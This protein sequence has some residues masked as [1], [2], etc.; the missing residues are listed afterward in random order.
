MTADPGR[1]NVYVS[2]LALRRDDWATL[3]DE[4]EQARAARFRFAADRARFVLGA[5][6]V[7]AAAG[8]ALGLPPASIAVDRECDRCGEQHGRPRIGGTDLHVSVSHSGD[9]VV[10][11]LT[12]EGPVGVD[13]EAVLGRSDTDY[14]EI[15]PSVCT[16]DEQRFVTGPEEFVTCW[17]RKEAVLKAVGVGLRL[18]MTSVVVTPPEQPPRLIELRGAALPPC[19]MSDL[20]AGVGYRGAVAVLTASPVEFAVLDATSLVM[21]R[22]HS[23]T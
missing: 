19:R 20:D 17:T 21:S 11:A 7:R 23:T 1:C 5:V 15:C 4:Q 18:P 10:A 22:H 16:E 3:L 9:V 6:L 14:R 8:H 2:R 12:A 13:V